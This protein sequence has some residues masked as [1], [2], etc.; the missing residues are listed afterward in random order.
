MKDILR[1]RDAVSKAVK[2]AIATPR[3]RGGAHIAR[4]ADFLDR[5]LPFATAG[6]L[7]RGCLVCFSYEAL[8]GQAADGTVHR[9]AAALEITHSALLIHDDIMDNDTLR[10]GRAS[11][12]RQYQEQAKE[13]NFADAAH[14]GVSIALGGGDLA[15]FLAFG[16][17]AD[18]PAAARTLFARQLAVTCA[19]QMQDIY[20]EARPGMP[21][22]KDIEA[23]MAAKTASYSLSLPL[24]LGAVLAEQPAA[25]IGQLQDFGVAAGTIFQIRDDE[26]GVMGDSGATGKPVGS[27]IKEGKKTLLAYHLFER[28]DA[29][30]KRKLQAIFG[31]AAATAQDVRFVRQLAERHGM[32]A[33]LNDEIGRLESRAA[34]VIDD[35]TVP[36]TM[37]LTM[38]ELV[39]FCAQRQS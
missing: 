36:D 11:M 25:V 28:C 1:H 30:E 10:R 21:T 37:K 12:H 8:S 5:L 9:A 31:N 23:L 13:D 29:G 34:A 38:A 22:R 7:L 32:Q 17:L 6:K 20:L 15:L 4:Q 35:M 24:A 27:D 19:G 39:R 14:Y 16:L 26:L 3:S 33:L 18:C 2:T